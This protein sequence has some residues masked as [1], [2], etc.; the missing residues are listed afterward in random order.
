MRERLTGPSLYAMPILCYQLRRASPPR[1]ADCRLFDRRVPRAGPCPG[2]PRL[3]PAPGLPDRT[4]VRRGQRSSGPG[5]G[6]HHAG[7]EPHAGTRP[8]RRRHQAGSLP[9]VAGRDHGGDGAG[10]GGSDARAVR[11]AARL[12]GDLERPAPAAQPRSPAARHDASRGA[13]RRGGLVRDLRATGPGAG[14]SWHLHQGAVE[15]DA[16]RPARG[17]EPQHVVP[18][19]HRAEA[20]H[21]VGG[22]LLGPALRPHCRLR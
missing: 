20:G 15:L 6:H 14:R 1:S 13:H 17:D 12:H 9:P 22:A 5:P 2:V 7:L 10:P 21:V 19:P 3:A 18:Q 16:R 11:R 8:S 4:A